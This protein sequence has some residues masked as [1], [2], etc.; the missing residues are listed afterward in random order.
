[1]SAAAAA[2][3][4]IGLDVT[5]ASALNMFALLLNETLCTG[6]VFLLNFKLNINENRLFGFNC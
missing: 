6:L 1:M 4:D 2:A 3:A 5:Q